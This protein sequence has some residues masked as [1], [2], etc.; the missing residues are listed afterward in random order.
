MRRERVLDQM[1]STGLLLA[2]AMG[3]GA[4]SSTDNKQ[5][6]PDAA[7]DTAKAPDLAP[8]A[9][10]VKAPDQAPPPADVP[11]GPETQ[12]DGADGAPDVAVGKADS[13]DA[14]LADASDAGAGDV[15]DALVVCPSQTDATVPSG[16]APMQAPGPSVASTQTRPQLSAALADS[17]YT[18]AKAL[19]RG[20]AITG[21]PTPIVALP[22]DGGAIDG[23]SAAIDAGSAGI[24]AGSATT[25]V[26]YALNDD[27][28]PVKN[29]IGDVT[30]FDPLYTV[31]SDGSG[32]HTT[33]NQAILDAQPQVQCGRVYIRIKAGTYREKVSVPSKT[34][35]ALLTLY[36]TE[37]DASKTVIAYGTGQVGMTTSATMTVNAKTGFQMKNIT[38]VNDFAESA[39]ATEDQAAVALLNQGD[40]AQY[41]N[42]RIL[43]NKASLY[44]KSPDT[45]TASRS[46]FRD[47]YVEGDEDIVSGR[48]VAVF[49]HTEIKTITSRRPTGGAITNPSTMLNNRYG[50]LFVSCNFT[51]DAG[52]ADVA[53]GHQWWESSNNGVIG[54]VIIRNSTL[55][56]HIA[57]A[58]W[59]PSTTRTFTP[60]DPGG[61]APVTLYTSDDYYPAGTGP[62]PAEI[63]LG[64]YGNSGAGAAK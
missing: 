26:T 40:R 64:E 57:A 55:G 11:V 61:T 51:A 6:T 56:G 33:I 10:T 25:P 37:A 24:D 52:A 35:A 14:V 34:T 12:A 29:G 50:L 47:C 39:T 7:P 23:G 46:Y 54:K 41:E 22:V 19:A 42:V 21:P 36:S 58:P 13:Q 27:W 9:D 4:C 28:D 62:S 32:T 31:A 18:I 16:T 3:W 2:L 49:D 45:S 30:T 20:G 53:L 43:G 59:A 44:L 15:G 17:D 5:T 38:V 60:K 8:A 48:G 63:Y 1:L